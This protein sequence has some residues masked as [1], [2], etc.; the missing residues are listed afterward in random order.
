MKDMSADLIILQRLDDNATQTFY[1]IRLITNF[2]EC[3]LEKN[4]NYSIQKR[5]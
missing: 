2:T 4:L 5:D 3:T 1:V